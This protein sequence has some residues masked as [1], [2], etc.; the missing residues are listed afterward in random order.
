MGHLVGS[1]HPRTPKKESGTG[2]SFQFR[3]EQFFARSR[4]ISQAAK[5]DP[6]G[7]GAWLPRVNSRDCAEA[8]RGT[9]QKR[10]RRLT[11]RL[12]KGAI[13]GWKLAEDREDRLMAEKPSVVSQR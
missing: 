9:S 4:A 2:V 12:R 3:N 7:R 8:Y 13:Y 10:S 1:V 11:P 6:P 5:L